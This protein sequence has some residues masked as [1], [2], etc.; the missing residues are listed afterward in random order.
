[1]SRSASR[2]AA[3]LFC[4]L[5]PGTP[6]VSAAEPALESSF[7]HRMAQGRFLLGA[8][9][10]ADALREFEAAVEMSRG[11]RD[12]RV[13]A[14]IATVRLDLGRIAGAVE[15]VRTARVLVGSEAGP[16]LLELH[17]FLTTRFGKVLVIG[18]GTQNAQLPTPILPILDP[19]LKRLF[20]VAIS[21]FG[22]LERGGSTSVYL[23][24]GSYRVGSHIVS[25]AARKTVRMDVRAGVGSAGGG[26]YGER[27]EPDPGTVDGPNPEPVSGTAGVLVR[28]GAVGFAIQGSA[29]GGG[30][31]LF[32]PEGILD[33]AGPD[34]V[35]RAA[36]EVAV[37]TLE[38]VR[39]GLEPAPAMAV[40]PGV[41]LGLGAHVALPGNRGWVL[42]GIALSLGYATPLL[43][44]LPTEYVGPRQ[45][46][47]YG[48][49][50]ELR[51]R[52]RPASGPVHPELAAR[53]IY[54]EAQPLDPGIDSR[55][56]TLVGGGLG[57]A[58]WFSP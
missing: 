43:G 15:A 40:L 34:L 56:H 33:V 28:F 6:A 4:L 7:E 54:R 57:F 30:A 24:I 27:A 47:T 26:V 23:P 17:D 22:Q 29:G 53:F 55:P 2:L 8:G 37:H 58:L 50:L 19:E 41:N 16:E 25:V 11:R 1:M 36:A 39:D 44:S 14:L 38:R 51:V 3:L 49:D 31:L 13:H 5:G 20:G 48:G 45:Y 52:F 12:G 42:P 46:L 32:G 9:Q 10:K 18:G 21:R 35:L